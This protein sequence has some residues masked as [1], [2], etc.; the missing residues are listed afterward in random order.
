MLII[1]RK[2]IKNT[3]YSKFVK[4]PSLFCPIS[5][6]DAKEFYYDIEYKTKYAVKPLSNDIVLN[7]SIA[8]HA[9]NNF[10]YNSHCIDFNKI[11][12]H[13]MYNR[14]KIIIFDKYKWM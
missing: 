4:D 6:W 11:E 14:L 12:K 2:I 5:W 8:V 3:E 7:N 9:W 1:F 10:T 13:S